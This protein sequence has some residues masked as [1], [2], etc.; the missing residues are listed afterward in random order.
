MKHLV[1]AHKTKF[2][3][4]EIKKQNVNKGLAKE[5]FWSCFVSKCNVKT[6]SMEDH[7]IHIA[8]DHEKLFNALMHDKRNNL[9]NVAKEL[10]PTKFK[11]RRDWGRGSAGSSQ[12]V[13]KRNLERV[14]AGAEAGPSKKAK[15]DEEDSSFT[16]KLLQQKRK[17]R[18]S[19]RLSGNR[20][21]SGE[22]M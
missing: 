12:K 13:A 15:K 8:V 4:D 19:Q 16:E 17:T 7:L 20:Q 3:I 10:F 18:K 5:E 11:E 2:F 1:L 22:E 6:A 9:K 21:L 14:D